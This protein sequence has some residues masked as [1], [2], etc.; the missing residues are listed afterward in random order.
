MKSTLDKE[1]ES[2]CEKWR[3]QVGSIIHASIHFL[4]LVIATLGHCKGAAVYP[5]MHWAEVSQT[6]ANTDLQYG[7]LGLCYD[8]LYIVLWPCLKVFR[9][10]Y[11]SKMQFVDQ[12]QKNQT[13]K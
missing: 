9:C 5:T 8:T 2:A 3:V 10:F 7:C 4:Y 11:M 6:A 13:L 12:E 1:R